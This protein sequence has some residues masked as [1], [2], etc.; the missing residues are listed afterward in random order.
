LTQINTKFPHTV[1]RL[2]IKGCC[3]H[4]CSH[5]FVVTSVT[6]ASRGSGHAR[7]VVPATGQANL[8]SVSLTPYSCTPAFRL[9]LSNLMH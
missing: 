1:R 9:I 8:T 5:R 3:H 6:Q 2:L 4:R 7:N